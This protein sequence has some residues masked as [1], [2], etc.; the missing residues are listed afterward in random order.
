MSD[1]KWYR[2]FW[3]GKSNSLWPGYSGKARK[4]LGSCHLAWYLLQK[5]G[6]WTLGL[7]LQ[8]LDKAFWHFAAEPNAG[9]ILFFLLKKIFFKFLLKYNL[10]T[11]Y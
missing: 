2:N 10:F 9:P 5:R 7:R 8:S 6:R 4:S 11:M 1:C 3:E